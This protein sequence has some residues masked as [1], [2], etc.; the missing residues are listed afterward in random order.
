MKNL[1]LFIYT[2][3]IEGNVKNSIIL[4]SVIIVC[5]L[6]IAFGPQFLFKVCDPTMTSTG[7]VEDCCATPEESDCCDPAASI[8]SEDCCGTTA[9]SLPICHWTA[10]AELGMGM[11]ILA[12]AACIIIFGDLKIQFG[13]NIGIFLSSIIALCFPHLLIGGCETANM[14]C[15]KVAF[16]IL[17]IICI[18]VLIISVIE[19]ILTD[20][21]IR[22]S[23]K[24]T[25]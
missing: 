3:T 23:Q 16:P 22:E 20:R 10:Q 12:L 19:M 21:K 6:L 5:G 13:L 2:S 1:G 4:S 17:S 9:S 11:L 15:R 14:A 8:E 7:E 24:S 25:L 18:L